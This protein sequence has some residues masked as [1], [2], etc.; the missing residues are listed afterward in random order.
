MQAA[1]GT[2]EEKTGAASSGRKNSKSTARMCRGAAK[3]Q[4][5][6]N[7]ARDTKTK[8]QGSSGKR[9]ED[10][11]QLP[12]FYSKQNQKAN[13]GLLLNRRGQSAT[14]YAEKAE[15][16]TTFCTSI[17][18]STATPNL[19]RGNKNLGGCKQTQQQ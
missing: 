12:S 1:W 4:L 16:L 14:N 5:K 10:P 8:R 17:F 3:A 18:S 11:F 19:D 9:M 15:I 6:L 7:L 2:R 13:T